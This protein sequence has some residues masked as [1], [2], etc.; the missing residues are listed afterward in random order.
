MGV[1]CT[2]EERRVERDERV[3]RLR[4]GWRAESKVLVVLMMMGF[5]IDSDSALFLLFLFFFYSFLKT[6]SQSR[7]HRLVSGSGSWVN[8]GGNILQAKH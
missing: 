7:P 1:C 8:L 4:V 5:V 3:G 6:R 2:R